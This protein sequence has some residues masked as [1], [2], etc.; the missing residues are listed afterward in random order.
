MA[1]ADKREAQQGLSEVLPRPEQKT[2]AVIGRT[3][4]D[5]KPA[6][7]N[8]SP[9]RKVRPM[10]SSFCWMMSASDKLVLSAAPSPRRLLTV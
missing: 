4:K 9:L 7:P 2:G 10:S 8:P 6:F 3:Y 1:G 5:S